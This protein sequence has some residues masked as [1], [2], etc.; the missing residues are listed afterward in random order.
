MFIGLVGGQA[1]RVPA[2]ATA[3]GHRS[4]Q[5]VINV[6]ARWEP[7]AQDR[8]CTSW[9]R[10]FFQAA[11]PYSTGGVYVNFMSEDETGVDRV[12]QAYGPN[13]QRLVELKR[14]YDPKNLFSRNQNI[15]PATAR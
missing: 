14:K 6:H 5:Y 15:R 2:T 12:A 4:H 11:A 10:E 3:Y 8:A 13:Y 7:P 9:A 1:N